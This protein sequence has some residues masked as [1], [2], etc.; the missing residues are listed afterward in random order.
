MKAKDKA[1]VEI[2]KR[3]AAT[4]QA[5][6]LV[7]QRD[8]ADLI[9]ASANQYSNWENGTGPIPVP[10]A[11][12]FCDITGATLD[13]IYRDVRAGLPISLAQKLPR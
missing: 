9:G 10:F 6:G 4:R 8:M 5:F 12:R 1:D 11:I 3:L 13:Y 7:R 2:G